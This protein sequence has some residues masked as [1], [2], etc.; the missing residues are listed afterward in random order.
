MNDAVGIEA[1]VFFLAVVVGVPAAAQRFETGSTAVVVDVVVRDRGG[2]FVTGLTPADFT[3][4]EDGVPQ[5]IMSLQLVGSPPPASTADRPSAPETAPGSSPAPTAPEQPRFT[6]LVFD[7]LEAKNAAMTRA[8]AAAAIANAGRT[9]V[10]GVFLI[11]HGLRMM[12][13]FT[14][15]KARLKRVWRGPS[16][17]PAR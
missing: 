14:T 17:G 12:Q 7:R 11:D 5:R 10:I 6:A 15:D 16:I 13:P 8:G 9:D 2:R 4:A 1:L 3:V